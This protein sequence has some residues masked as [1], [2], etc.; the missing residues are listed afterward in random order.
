LKYQECQVGRQPT[1]G[2]EKKKWETKNR[3][4]GFV[5]SH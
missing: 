4:I 5:G 3:T 1:I 2:L